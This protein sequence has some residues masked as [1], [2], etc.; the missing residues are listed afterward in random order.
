[1]SGTPHTEART[2]GPPARALTPLVTPC[3]VT[4]CV[5]AHGDPGDLE[6]LLRSLTELDHPAELTR[7]V[8]AVDGPDPALEAVADRFGAEAVVLP[9]N[10][11]SYAAR[12]AAIEQLH[13]DCPVV[14]FTDTDVVTGPR[15]VSAH[16]EA[17]R[18]TH[19]S[20]G[21]IHVTTSEPPTPAEYVDATRHLNQRLLV[22][23]LG[24]GA[25]ANLAVRREVL[26]EVTFDRRLRSGGDREFGNRA[27]AAGFSLVYTEDATVMH[28]ARATPRELFRKV[29]RIARGIAQ[30]RHL[31][32]Y[33]FAVTPY[34]RPNA[35]QRAHKE[36][37]RLGW[38]WERQVW[39]ID[40]ACDLIWVV[41]APSAITPAVRR[42]IGSLWRRH[43]F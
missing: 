35:V 9:T 40:R 2:A 20:G 29:D 27:R 34:D 43:G 6:S 38:W 31:G 33:S 42:R 4:I 22:E 23:A 18:H 28:P 5:P 24:H 41:R 11:G 14:L 19:M 1:M 13:R 25:T 21:A 17:L 30:L 37:V 32:T 16:L 10:Q 39:A 12:N 3:P 15:W 36:G 7:V 8:V 26:D